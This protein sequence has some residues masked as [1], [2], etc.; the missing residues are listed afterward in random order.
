M[1]ERCG[2]SS[3]RLASR[4]GFLT[5]AA[6][7]AGAAVL[8]GGPAFLRPAFAQAP[9]AIPPDEALQRLIEGNA[10]YVAGEPTDKDFEAGR[11]ARA[12]AQY[13]FASIL[14]CA[15][16]RV[17]PELTFDQGPGDLFVV[18]VAGN[19]AADDG[20]ASL[21]YGSAVLGVPLILVLGHTSC[22]AVD[23]AIKVVKDNAELP[24]HLPQ[25]IGHI[26]P[27][28]KTAME[29]NPPDLLAAATAQNV[30]NAMARLSDDSPVLSGMIAGGKVKVVGGIYEIASGRV[31]LL[32]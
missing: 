22:G 3:H 11:A 31:S 26:T 23:A 10:R 20:I 7:L 29:G 21:E 12:A 16:S 1:C 27:A 9:N 17:A 19:V 24:G 14:S 32:T 4:R 6:A 25:L 30:R 8:A 2:S 18:R 15:D 28:V 13:P 5:G